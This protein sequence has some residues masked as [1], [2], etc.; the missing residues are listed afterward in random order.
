MQAF[1]MA[2]PRQTP[3]RPPVDFADL[4][5][6]AALALER[7]NP[8]AA[9]YFLGGAADERAMDGNAAVYAL[10]QIAPPDRAARSCRG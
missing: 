7:P 9:A 6:Y 5:D 10:R 2:H 3:D 4:A 8:N 1:S